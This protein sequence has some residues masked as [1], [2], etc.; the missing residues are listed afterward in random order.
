[1]P[2]CDQVEAHSRDNNHHNIENV[3]D[4]SINTVRTQNLLTSSTSKSTGSYFEFDVKRLK[5]NIASLNNQLRK[6]NPL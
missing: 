5:G 2:R 4:E 3:F 1:M 6:S